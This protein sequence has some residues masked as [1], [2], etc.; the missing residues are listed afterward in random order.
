MRKNDSDFLRQISWCAMID[1]LFTICTPVFC[2]LV[3]IGALAMIFAKG[4]R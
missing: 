2:A 3:I 1:R 4:M